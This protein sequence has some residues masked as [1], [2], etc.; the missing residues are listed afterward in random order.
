MDVPFDIAMDQN[1][2]SLVFQTIAGNR[3]S[4]GPKEVTHP[5]IIHR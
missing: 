1:T 5:Y 3:H 4:D 2:G